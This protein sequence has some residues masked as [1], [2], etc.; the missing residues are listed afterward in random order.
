MTTPAQHV[1]EGTALATIG[2]TL[3]GWLPPLAA[4]FAILWYLVLLY[5]RFVSGKDKQGRDQ[6]SGGD[7]L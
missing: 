3:A 4:A 6:T 5:D 2:A 1:A 7:G